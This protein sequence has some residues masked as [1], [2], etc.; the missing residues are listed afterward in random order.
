MSFVL[1][2]SILLCMILESLTPSLDR[3]EAATG[4]MLTVS[5]VFADWSEGVG[6]VVGALLRVCP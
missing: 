5:V 3:F 6:G 1:V 4:W 2:L